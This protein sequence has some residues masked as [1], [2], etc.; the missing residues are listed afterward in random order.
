MMIYNGENNRVNAMRAK[1]TRKNSKGFR[2]ERGVVL[3]AVLMFIAMILPITLLILD[4]VR[5]ESLL[6]V[7]EAYMKTAGDE[8][9]KGFQD[10]L[11]AI[12]ADQD[13]W[14]VDSSRDITDPLQQ[15]FVDTDP[16]SRSGK[17]EFDYLAEMW[18]RH[19][20]ND[21]LFLVERSLENIPHVE[22]PD[23]GGDEDIH[24]VPCRW[25]LMD[26][27]FGM[28]DFGEYHDDG[29][30]SPKL[31]LPFEYVGEYLDINA[32]VADIQYPAFYIDPSELSMLN[33]QNDVPG[34]SPSK[35]SSVDLAGLAW[36]LSPAD[37]NFYENLNS[38]DTI[39][40]FA[41][42]PASYF[43]NTSGDRDGGLIG[44]PNDEGSVT[45]AFVQEDNDAIDRFVYDCFYDYN[46]NTNQ[47]LEYMPLQQAV[48]ESTWA[49]RYFGSTG[50]SNLIT[51]AFIT[52]NK[53]Y[54]PTPGTITRYQLGAEEDDAVPGWHEAI[55]SDESNRFPINYLLNIVYA[56]D[57]VNYIGPNRENP[58]VERDDFEDDDPWT[59]SSPNYGGYLLARD[60]LTSL[61]LEDGDMARLADSWDQARFVSYQTKAVWLLRQMLRRREQLDDSTDFNR[62]GDYDDDISYGEIYQYPEMTGNDPTTE[63][64][65]DGSGRMGDGQDLWDGTWRVFTNPKDLLANFT[66]A[67]PNAGD[68]L[69]PGNFATLNQRVTFY[70]MDTE[71]TADPDHI[72]TNSSGFFGALDVR[73]NV[74]KMAQSDNPSTLWQDESALWGILR[75]EIGSS[76]AQ[77]ILN[78]RDGLVDLNGDGDL[79]D[80]FIEQPVAIERYDP[81]Q[82]GYEDLDNFPVS[83]ITYRERNH[84]NFQDPLLD[85]QF[86]DP[87]YLNIRN[88]GDMI[89]IP[90]S[91]NSGMIAYSTANTP[92]QL[93]DLVIKTENNQDPDGVAIT[94]P[95]RVYPDFSNTGSEIAYDDQTEVYRNDLMLSNEQS[96]QNDR[97]HPS[98]GPGD[99]TICYYD[100]DDDIHLYD[101]AADTDIE[102]LPDAGMPP[103]I[104]DT[105][106][107]TN[108]WGVWNSNNL[109]GNAI[110]EMGS[111]DISPSGGNNEIAF[112]QVATIGDEFLDPDVAYN[113]VSVRTDG[114]SL[115]LLT[116]NEVGTFDYAP[117]F[118]PDGNDIVFTK[119]TYHPQG[120]GITLTLDGIT[121]T[122]LYEMSRTGG[123]PNPM[124]N[125]F[126]FPVNS[127]NV[128]DGYVTWHHEDPND[129][130]TPRIFHIHQPMFPS[131]SPDG[132]EIIFMDLLVSIR[133]L[134]NGNFNAY[135]TEVE[136][137]KIDAGTTMGLWNQVT[138]RVTNPPTPG[139]YEIFPDWGVGKVQLA[140]QNNT[141]FGTLRGRA[142]DMS[143]ASQATT[144]TDN[145]GVFTEQDREWIATDIQNASLA[146]RKSIG[147]GADD[148][149]W[150]LK[151]LPSVPEHVVDVLEVI[152]DI[153][154][155]RDPYV[156]YDPRYSGT[157][158]FAGIMVPPLQAYPGRVNINTASRPV[159]RSLFL[160]MFQGPE[161]DIDNSNDVNGPH[162]RVGSGLTSN[163]LNLRTS[164]TNDYDR[165]MAM[166]I[167]DN[168]AHQV[169]EYRRWVYNNQGHLGITDETVPSNLPI[170]ETAFQNDAIFTS[171]YRNYRANP[172][173]PLVDTDNDPSND[174]DILRS[175]PD[176]PFRSIADLFKVM[177]YDDDTFGED[178]TYEGI[179]SAAGPA[180]GDLPR[181]YDSDGNP[182]GSLNVLDV[183]G[184]IYNASDERT[185]TH[186]DDGGHLAGGT[187]Y[188]FSARVD[189]DF[190]TSVNPTYNNF[191]EHQMFRLFSADDF[192]RIAPLITTRTYNYRIESRG[193]LRIAS[194]AARTDI[195][196]DKIW[197]ITTNTDAAFG[198]R[199]QPS[200]D[201]TNA[202]DSSYT[203]QNRG[204]DEYYVVYFEETPQS[205]LAITRGNFV[206]D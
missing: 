113:I 142:V 36:A 115:D 50:A 43:R 96:I 22:N 1:T 172:F 82:E 205:G 77:S 121:F 153:I 175:S 55:V 189:N 206:P 136:L 108:F 16:D 15:Y 109:I 181:A 129:N 132:D 84:S 200:L 29:G 45:F 150:L 10:A 54:K 151:D 192:R 71:H 124:V 128:D 39:V 73:L 186:P 33:L 131:Y 11:A 123:N 167:A 199:L 64:L 112:S 140:Y 48:A 89:T 103:D 2:D 171:H 53:E 57:N 26:V 133:A 169:C 110:F 118:S 72:R 185:C 170:Y 149:N 52:S 179:G 58:I 83:T 135:G 65:R 60:I 165:F 56:S 69:T 196:R 168:Y 74:Q 28:D 51:A 66:G 195:H 32:D 4:S 49:N 31:L 3:I 139:V 164:A 106:T 8:A 5:I 21:T 203:A 119:T 116:D 187:M 162:P 9:D 94:V 76:R 6:P 85:P 201:I 92:G 79:L 95:D 138:S 137:Y 204:D 107:L 35:F 90:M 87:D 67:D 127:Q 93:P 147:F 190:D 61:L 99:G 59:A 24:S 40:Q 42:R 86:I 155:F 104:T 102:V 81:S 173:Y 159:L 141:D 120:F 146:L 154:C 46:N 63:Y 177:V 12:I 19:P 47:Y 111:P 148:Q 176:P 178:W 41:P 7:N 68:E 105:T 180:S 144:D 91:F 158:P 197:I 198:G 117:D 44:L 182:T 78:W 27:P 174:P 70:S 126:Q 25:Q 188:G 157:D 125:W 18:A 152:G 101:F 98:W 161:Q 194:G 160:M 80:E 88:L 13:H 30:D 130:S 97:K 143:T 62:N 183:F 38:L 100:L 114:S 202:F 191:Y 166:M 34:S 156:T 122:N 17:H 14:L 193:V 184:P 75:R 145:G 23:A 20:D 37:P 163:Y 134:P